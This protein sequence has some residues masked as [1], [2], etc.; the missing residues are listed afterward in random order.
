MLAKRAKSFGRKSAEGIDRTHPLIKL[1]L[2]EVG[3]ALHA[4]NFR[5]KQQIYI[6]DFSK[7]RT[8]GQI[9]LLQVNEFGNVVSDSGFRTSPNNIDCFDCLIMKGESTKSDR[10]FSLNKSL[11][12]NVILTTKDHEKFGN[13]GFREFYTN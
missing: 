9:V 1:K 13:S 10:T 6:N 7:D 2:L 12:N 4:R 5:T 11:D 3:V 8:R